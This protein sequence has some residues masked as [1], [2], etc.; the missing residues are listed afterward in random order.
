MAKYNVGGVAISESISRI[1]DE[2]SVLGSLC[3]T[4]NNKKRENKAAN[5]P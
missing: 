3:A 4:V 5:K 2:S 1:D